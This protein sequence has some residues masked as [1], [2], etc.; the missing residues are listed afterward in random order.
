[1]FQFC[2]RCPWRRGAAANLVGSCVCVCVFVITKHDY[3]GITRLELSF[4]IYNRKFI[5]T[6]YCYLESIMVVYLCSKSLII[7]HQFK[8]YGLQ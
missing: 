7:E 6:V 3:G 8:I 4:S 5:C 2:V 1:M